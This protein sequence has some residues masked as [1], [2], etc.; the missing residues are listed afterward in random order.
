MKMILTL[1]N[2]IKSDIMNDSFHFDDSDLDSEDEF[3]E[4]YA[5]RDAQLL[6]IVEFQEAYSKI[7]KENVSLKIMIKNLLKQIQQFAVSTNYEETITDMI[8]FNQNTIIT[9]K[10][11]INYLNSKLFNLNSRSD[12]S[13]QSSNEITQNNEIQI[14]AESIYNNENIESLRK[15]I[16]NQNNEIEILKNHLSNQIEETDKLRQEYSLSPKSPGKPLDYSDSFAVTR[17][18]MNLN[19]QDQFSQCNSDDIIKLK[20]NINMLVKCITNFIEFINSIMQL[21]IKIYEFNDSFE[22]N[23]LIQQFNDSLNLLKDEL[24]KLIAVRNRSQLDY[25]LRTVKESVNRFS[26]ELKEEHQELLEKIE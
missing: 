20:L 10:N 23:I 14:D 22:I 8:I 15:I 12:A 2:L 6:D 4:I 7:R 21:N 3:H 24:P 16:T 13:T 17:E 26:R 25:L 11:R 5:E 18:A 1:Y 19:L 9:L